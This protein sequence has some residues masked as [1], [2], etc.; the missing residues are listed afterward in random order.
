MLFKKSPIAGHVVAL[1]MILLNMFLNMYLTYVYD[2]KAGVFSFE[3]F[4]L[5]TVLG[6]KPYCKLGS[7]A[8]G[9]MFA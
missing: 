6:N 7:H 5:F 4:Y 3:D 2:L 1:L 9:V 8:F